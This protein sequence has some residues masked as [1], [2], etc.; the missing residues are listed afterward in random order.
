MAKHSPALGSGR[1]RG[2]DP[3]SQIGPTS[4][5]A[6]LSGGLSG[7][8]GCAVVRLTAPLFRIEGVRVMQAGCGWRAVGLRLQ[9]HDPASTLFE[10]FLTA[11]DGRDMVIAVLDED[12]AVACWRNAGKTTL[13]PLLLQAADGS[14]SQPYP[15]V[16]AVAL[17][18]HHF[19][20]QH[21]FLR[22]RRPRFLMRRKTGARASQSPR[23]S[24]Q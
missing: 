15:Q 9:H 6:E 22:H 5:D 21:S 18:V 10:I 14:T 24:P 1:D 3:H 13:L 19:R 8:G 4:R 20:R 23:T 2:R 11:G 16:G 17:G 7:L 12:D